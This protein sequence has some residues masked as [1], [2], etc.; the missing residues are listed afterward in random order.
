MVRDSRAGERT[1]R[2]ERVRE[3]VSAGRP[4]NKNRWLMA[5]RSD[6]CRPRGSGDQIP[7]GTLSTTHLYIEDL[8]SKGFNYTYRN[9]NRTAPW[10]F[11]PHFLNLPRV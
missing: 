5:P 8:Y 10:L 7:R 4:V 9:I 3:L 6:G 1:A 2:G 11:W